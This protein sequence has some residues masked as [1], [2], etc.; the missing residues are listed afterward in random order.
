[1]AA[2]Q[3]FQTIIP[4]VFYTDILHIQHP[5]RG[6][7]N[8]EL[9]KAYLNPWFMVRNDLKLRSCLIRI[10]LQ[11]RATYALQFEVIKT[12]VFSTKNCTFAKSG[13]STTTIIVSIVSSDS[14]VRIRILALDS[15]D[16]FHE[17]GNIELPVKAKR[18]TNGH[19]LFTSRC[20]FDPRSMTFHRSH[21]HPEPPRLPK[22]LPLALHVRSTIR[23]RM[24]LPRRPRPEVEMLR[25]QLANAQRR[26]L[27][28]SQ[29]LASKST[30]RD[31]RVKIEAVE[32]TY[33]LSSPRSQSPHKLAASLG[34][35]VLLCALPTLL[36]MPSQNSF[37]TSFSLPTAFPASSSS[38]DYNSLFPPNFDWSQTLD[39]DERGRISSFPQK[40]EFSNPELSRALSGLD[41]S[42]DAVPQEDG[43]IRVRIHPSSSASSRAGSPGLA[44]SVSSSDGHG[45][46]GL[47]LWGLS[48][49]DNPTLHPFASD[50]SYYG[51]A[52]SSFTAY[53]PSSS[54]G[55]PF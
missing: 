18:P 25:A 50:P 4:S 46:L 31:P 20:A 32:P 2:V 41:I 12:Y 16:Q 17:L 28:L 19:V 39:T 21:G 14:N 8:L 27:E 47:D 33:P 15:E 9:L 10:D 36:S 51:G 48:D 7:R 30:S 54:N 38:P 44:N 3:S 29:E 13:P 35:M 23:H 11:V 34:L 24:L 6:H 53:S 45:A 55:D 42:F 22:L 26:E 1:M 52:S 40:L 5:Q 37:S 43:K 49:S